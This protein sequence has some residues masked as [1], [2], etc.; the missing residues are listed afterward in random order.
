MRHNGTWGT[1]FE[2]MLTALLFDIQL[3]R[4][5]NIPGKLWPFCSKQTAET[6]QYPHYK[7]MGNRGSVYLYCHALHALLRPQSDDRA[8]NHFAFLK[9]CKYTQYNVK[10]L[11]Y[12][13][14]N[15]TKITAY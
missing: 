3:I 13:G 14:G 4:L 11:I 6:Y 5:A 1:S 9:P 15:E 8:L 10:Q 12:F 2:M 7:L